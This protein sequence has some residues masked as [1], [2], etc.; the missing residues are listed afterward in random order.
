M[1]LKL[2]TLF[3]ALSVF[4]NSKDQ[5]K[6]AP[7]KIVLAVFA[8]PDDETPVDPLLHKL[9]REGNEVWVVIATNG[10]KGV[11]EFAKIPA[12]DSL[13]HVRRREAECV[14]QTLGIHDSGVAGVG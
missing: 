11:R 1:F 13:A 9:A 7:S 8:H 2:L 6:P 5:K 4:S 3:F 10:E 12:G 14:C